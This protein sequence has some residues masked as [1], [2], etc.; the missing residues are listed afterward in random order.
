MVRCHLQ[1]EALVGSQERAGCLLFSTIHCSTV[2]RTEL[3]SF[4]TNKQPTEAWT[5]EYIEGILLK[6]KLPFSQSTD[7]MGSS[8]ICTRQIPKISEQLF[9]VGTIIA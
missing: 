9:H 8:Y 3:F 7:I 1:L 6:H 4:L 5:I 2:Y